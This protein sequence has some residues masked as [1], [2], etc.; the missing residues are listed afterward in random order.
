L[1]DVENYIHEISRILKH[2]QKCFVT[3]F[4]LN[5][6]SL[7][8]IEKGLVTSKKF[9]YRYE[10]YM[11]TNEKIPEETISHDELLIK[12]IIEDS[13][14]LIQDPIYYGSWSGKKETIAGQD[15]IIALKK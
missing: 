1:E 4:L 14:L 11:T 9:K 7:E 12:K 3:F 2:C 15:V 6:N 13:G 8:Q 5:K 10:G